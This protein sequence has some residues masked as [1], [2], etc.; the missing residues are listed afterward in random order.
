MSD[1]LTRLAERALGLGPMVRP[2]IAPRFAEDTRP[3]GLEP[4]GE[5][6]PLPHRLQPKEREPEGIVER[7]ETSRREP[8]PA[9]VRG[10]DE[11]LPLPSRLQPERTSSG[12]GA[13]SPAGG[14][15]VSSSSAGASGAAL[16]PAGL[17]EPSPP[18][19]PPGSVPSSPAGLSDSSSADP[20]G[21]NSSP[22]G[23]SDSP[24]P[25]VPSGSV[26]PSPAG[27]ADSSPAVFPSGSEET[28]GRVAEIPPPPRDGSPPAPPDPSLS[29]G[30]TAVEE[31]EGGEEREAAAP[32]RPGAEPPRRSVAQPGE[33][34]GKRRDEPAR[35]A[36]DGSEKAHRAEA[37]ERP[38]EVRRPSPAV[39]PQAGRPRTGGRPGEAEAGSAASDSPE[40]SPIQR[41]A[42]SVP[43]APSSS[44][45][46]P[47]G[48][49]SAT[50]SI[51]PPAIPGT[52]VGPVGVTEALPLG[53]S[54]TPE[55][56]GTT[57]AMSAE[58]ARTVPSVP[59]S[60]REVE[61]TRPDSARADRVG[62]E[63]ASAR[64][65]RPPRA[66]ASSAPTVPH[67]NAAMNPPVESPT[68]PG[69]PTFPE[70]EAIRGEGR[71]PTSPHPSLGLGRTEQDRGPGTTAAGER[72]GAVHPASAAPPGEPPTTE[73][74]VETH[75]SSRESQA[76]RPSIEAASSRADLGRKPS[77][78]DRPS[79]PHLEEKRPPQATSPAADRA[80]VSSPSHPPSDGPSLIQTVASQAPPPTIPGTA[81]GPAGA[82][83]VTE[84]QPLGT[85]RS[86]ETAEPS[87]AMPAEPARSVP[88][89]SPSASHDRETTRPISTSE[90]RV[91]ESPTVPSSPTFHEA[92]A[93]REEGSP[94]ASPH[95]PLELG[96][97][98]QGG[99]PRTT[100]GERLG[101]VHPPSAALPG[102]PPAT[103]R[104]V[105]THASS[106]EGQAERP[107]IEAAS[108][109]AALDRK[110]SSLDRPS[111]PQPVEKG[112]PQAT[113]PAAD[114]PSVSPPSHPPSDG[115]SPIQT[116]ASQAPPPT[117]PG[118]AGGPAG[119]I[120]VTEAQPLGTSQTAETARASKKLPA[121]PAR[122]APSAPPSSR[123]AETTLPI[124]TPADQVGAELASARESRP[125]QAEASSAPTFPEAEAIRGEGRPAVPPHPSLELGTTEQDGAPGATPA[126]ERRGASHPP[127]AAPPGEPPTTERHIRAQAADREGQAERPSIEAASSQA[128]LDRRLSSLDR[129]SPPHPEE[130]VPAKP[131]SPAAD[132]ASVSSPSQPPSDGPSPIQTVASQAPTPAIAP[133]AIPGTA[134]G[135]V[136]PVGVTEA[137]PL[138][139]SK[140]AETA[141]ASKELPA[142]PARTA[143]SAPPSTRQAETTVPISTS[144]E[145]VGAELASA[146]G[147]KSPRAEASSAPT[148]PE[149][150]A[151]RGEGRA[152]A[153]PHPSL[154]LGRTEQDGAPE[155]TTP[156]ERRGAV[157][158]PTAEPPGEPPTT[159]KHVEIHATD[160]EGQVERPSIET[161]SSRADL[162]RELSSLD[163]SSA[164]VPFPATGGRPPAPP[165]PSLPLGMTRAGDAP[166]DRVAAEL[167]SA[168]EPGS[169][170][171]EASSAP[172]TAPRS[173]RPSLLEAETTSALPAPP[174]I[175]SG[176]EESG[177]REAEIPFPAAGGRP[178][179]HPD[180]SLPLRMTRAPAAQNRAPIQRTEASAAP[181]PPAS[182][183]PAIPAIPATPAIPSNMAPPSVEPSSAARRSDRIGSETPA[184]G[185]P[186]EDLEAPPQPPHRTKTADEVP[187]EPELA[188]RK[189]GSLEAPE[190]EPARRSRG[191]EP[192]ADAE[193]AEQRPARLATVR[194]SIGRVEVRV[195][196]TTKPS[197][198]APRRPSVPSL[199]DYLAERRGRR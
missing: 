143:P 175:P 121:E 161:A 184:E 37:G 176:S 127:S 39:A 130:K 29:L 173:G 157:H 96:R 102:E 64:E 6:L 66:E 142:E 114:R 113:S 92:E 80:S 149:A 168:R 95:P 107:S 15:G 165:D 12:A 177:G 106:R 84:V 103:E 198:P 91:A 141:R 32:P 33:A 13:S 14:S 18:A 82:I 23:F 68:V 122:T 54:Q 152:P 61:K 158:T 63:L 163:G 81:G 101:T 94:P 190:P 195:A 26:P 93:I 105:V 45:A 193:P 55:P 97:T 62:A 9:P 53:A 72:R 36:S 189:G 4:E 73:K 100:P 144:G 50:R 10:E 188:R 186:V 170:R 76:E 67:R 134:D 199:A 194:I 98:E 120:G 178:P 146:H 154:G 104:H 30:M 169:P 112:L 108:P 69:S 139:T 167:A 148:F 85:S 59:P 128:A 16:P 182:T 115:P 153:L 118:T 192:H 99:A 22:S 19:A 136:G 123:Q 77:S 185:L 187:P 145:Q 65:S 42:E 90:D 135:P 155:T 147:S 89:I 197:R 191:L 5:P 109:G 159:G 8:A 49:E 31:G 46:V 57:T 40:G 17:S 88:S 133:P 171:A 56:A 119:A 164:E 2:W 117:I 48:S 74:H 52:T 35:E 43:A 180:P 1:Y 166:D 131:A 156:G 83:G 58:P 137:Q 150:E 160:R 47:A 125:P 151:I 20:S 79:T 21:S 138:G 174:V 44:E 140:T 162:G 116:A 60:S 179:A 3:F 78:L 196:E 7:A 129:P 75:A 110:P 183:P 132:R 70:S 34:F 24:V 51:A 111:T 41:A 181:A 124:S 86:A 28:G 25:A 27:L 71:P 11:P 126:G 38:G 87:K 172:T